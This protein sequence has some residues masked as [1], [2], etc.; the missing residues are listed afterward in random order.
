MPSSENPRATIYR[1]LDGSWVLEQTDSITPVA[2]RQTFE[3]DGKVFR[4]CCHAHVSTTTV[5]D[6]ALDLELR[7]AR[8]SLAVSRDEE[9]VELKVTCGMKSFDLGA[10]AHNYLLLTL[11]RR[12]LADAA[13]GLPSPSCGWLSPDD[14][15]HDPA[16]APARLN[17]DVLRIRKQFAALGI[18]DAP[19][20]IERRARSRQLRIGV[21]QITIVTI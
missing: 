5:A 17:L 21:E 4:F 3:L 15:P 13:E 19:G 20:I 6:P 1:T 8:L 18:V 7:R 14:F 11:G 16:M 2:N 10:R 9:H 12:R